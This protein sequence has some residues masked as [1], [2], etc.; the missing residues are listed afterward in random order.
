MQSWETK[1]GGCHSLQVSLGR[2]ESKTLSQN[3][4]I[5]VR[6]WRDAAALADGSSSLPS[7]H[8]RWFTATYGSSPG[9]SD[10]FLWPT[11]GSAHKEV[12]AHR[13]T[14]IKIKI[15]LNTFSWAWDII[16]LV[17]EHLPSTHRPWVLCQAP[18]QTNP[19]A[20]HMYSLTC[21]HLSCRDYP[22]FQPWRSDLDS[23]NKNSS[24][25]ILVSV[26]ELQNPQ[27]RQHARFGYCQSLWTWKLYLAGPLQLSCVMDS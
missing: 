3:I 19:K 27:G 20:P 15:N 4:K 2:L 23:S 21:L 17:V 12:Y 1:A 11:L 5:K 18:H 26:P 22:H 24:K 13:D 25:L 6:S 14:C 16:S 9:E 10:A 8:I 7:V